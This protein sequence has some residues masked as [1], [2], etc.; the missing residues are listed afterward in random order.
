[1]TIGVL[2]YQSA[3]LV[4]KQRGLK[5]SVQKF[6]AIPNVAMPD[7][8]LPN[9]ALPDVALPNVA[10]PNVAMPGYYLLHDNLLVEL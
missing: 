6:H 5:L 7:V 10:M 9:V 4:I 8:A 2:L 1:M 3:S